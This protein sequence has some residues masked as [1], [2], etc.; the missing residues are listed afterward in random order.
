MWWVCS[1]RPDQPAGRG[2]QLSESPVKQIARANGLCVQQPR[3][4]R[5]EAAQAELAELK[6]DVI[7]VAAYGLIVPQ[8]VL[9]MPAHGCLNVHGSLLPRHR[10]AA[11]IS[12]A[13]LGGDAITGIS[14]M[15]LD[16]GLD[17]GPVLSTAAL[18]IEPDDT[19]GTLSARAGNPGRPTPG[20]NSAPLAAPARLPRLRRT[21]A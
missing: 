13:I 7:V 21:I 4:L 3:T 6:P 15:L 10:G 19:T 11:P 8:A 1:T 17:T 9:D 5:S 12:A 2:K 16:A 18:R 14:I 20:G